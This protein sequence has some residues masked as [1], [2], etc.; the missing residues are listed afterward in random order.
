MDITNI[1]EGINRRVKRLEE[2]IGEVTDV[3]LQFAS[4]KEKTTFTDTLTIEKTDLNDSFLLG[5]EYPAD[6]NYY[7]HLGVTPLNGDEKTITTVYT[8]G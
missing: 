1:I 8:G 5:M 4:F 2:T 6:G 7:C 3:L